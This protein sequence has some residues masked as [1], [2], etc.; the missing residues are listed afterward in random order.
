M[1][2]RRLHVQPLQFDF[3][4]VNLLTIINIVVANHTWSLKIYIYI[5]AEDSGSNPILDHST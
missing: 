4:P 2:R 5:E 3:V 1:M